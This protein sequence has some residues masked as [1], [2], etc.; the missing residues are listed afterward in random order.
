MRRLFAI[1]VFQLG[2]LLWAGPS[3]AQES[4]TLNQFRASETPEDAFGLS[5]PDDQGH[6][7][8][9]VNLHVD[10]S[11][12]PLVYERQLGE[13]MTEEGSIVEHQLTGT[14]GLSIGLI[15]RL[16]IYAGLPVHFFMDGDDAMPE[17]PLPS[18]TAGLL[19]DDI[20][21][22]DIYLGMR[23]R[24][25][26]EAD[27]FFALGAQL[28][29]TFP[30][31]GGNYR[32]D[33]FLSIH[34]EVMAELRPG[35]LRMTLNLGARIGD[36]VT[37][38]GNVQIGDSMTFGIGLTA[39]LYGDH[40]DP[41]AIRL[42]LHAQLWGSTAFN[43]FFGREETP[44]EALGGLKAHLV[45]G[46]VFGAA[47]G[48]GITRGFGSP[49][50]RVIA[51]IG[52]LQPREVEEEPEPEPTDRD[53]DGIDDVDDQCPDDP[54]DVDSFED[55]DGC[56]DPDNDDDEILDA[57]DACPN[58]AEDRDDFED[59]DG[60]PDPDNDADG[61]AD[62]DDQCPVDPEDLDGFEDA[63]GCP[64]P[65]ND[66][67]EVPDI[68]DQCPMEAGPAANGGCPDADRDG[69]EVVDR[70]DNCPDEPGPA[71]NQG[72]RRR[73]QV[74]IREGG[75][76]ILDRVY[77]RVNSDRILSRSNRLLANVATVLNNHPEITRIRVEGHTDDRGDDDYNME[78]SQKRAEAVV[79][80]LTERGEVA[81]ERLEA[82]GFGETRPIEDNET[83]QGRAANRRVEFN[84]VGA[85]DAQTSNAPE[86][87]QRELEEPTDEAAE[88]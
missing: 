7:R 17:G 24:L 14:F 16:V 29:A 76:E 10:Y 77:F 61:I 15:D 49:D 56:P 81:A 75:L 63:D 58:E 54:E 62:G 36:D 41:S 66:A 43:S 60:C 12:D 5:R 42:D 55:A 38:P 64:D 67:D 30:T 78:L 1:S 19:A 13:R 9:G 53:G 71:E 52:Y 80:F 27:D 2:V 31:G 74:V 70:L 4:V 8:F 25:Y 84:L 23:A 83:R 34:P 3:V 87:V 11:N 68:A 26:G 46:V 45:N 20:G 57:T 72:C 18:G 39:P 69:D 86:Q 35:K 65:D 88:P 51:T 28:T 48:A 85:D 59:T 50:A 21:V 40:D 37:L 33:D 73:Q 79:T 44:M 47:A 6:L 32:G 82:R 22:G